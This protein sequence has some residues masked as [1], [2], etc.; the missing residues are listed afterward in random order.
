MSNR[1]GAA[2]A[3]G[4]ETGERRGS[5]AQRVHFEALVA[6][7][8]SNGGS[9]FEAESMDVSPEGMRLRTAYL[10][11]IGER[12]VC[13]FE[14]SGSEMVV[15]GEVIWRNEAAR[16]GEFGLRFT[17]LDR[18][19]AE[20]LRSL[21]AVTS[22]PSGAPG[23]GS[24]SSGQARGTRVRLHIDGLGS[25]MKARVR[26]SVT[27]EILVGS[28]LEFLRVGRS[29]ELEDVDHGVRREAHIDNVKV[30]IDPATS[31]PQL[32]VA[33]R[34][35][36]VDKKAGASASAA[37]GTAASA[38][39][40]KPAS[41][42]KART[43]A[44]PSAPSQGGGSE[45]QEA[46]TAPRAGEGR[47]EGR[48]SHRKIAS[49]EGGAE[50]G[51]EVREA[52]H[53]G[54]AEDVDG[55]DS[56]SD[57][58]GADDGDHAEAGGRAEKLKMLGDKA[59]SAGKAVANKVGPSLAAV[60]AKTKSAM[61]GLIAALQ[62]KR[63]E[64]AEANAEAEKDAAPRRVTALPP[65][66]AL[67]SEGRRLIRDENEMGEDELT[68]EPPK[69]NKRAAVIGSAVGL[70]A[71]LAVFGIT[72]FLGLHRSPE[73]ATAGAQDTAAALALPSAAPPTAPAAPASG[74]IMADVPLFG[75]T[76]LSTTEPVPAM[77]PTD[78]SAL[79]AAG[80]PG[81]APGGDPNAAAGDPE[82]DSSDGASAGGD[83][84]SGGGPAKK[85]WGQGSVRNPIVLRLKMDGPIEKLNGAAGAMGFTVS[86]PD[87]RSVSS[88]SELA[89]KDKRIA[90]L[91]V[92]NNAHGAEV[93]VQFKDGVPPY[94][95]KAKGDRLEISLGTEGRK[96]VAAKS[97]G[98][99]KK[100]S[101]ADAKKKGAAK[102]SDKKKKKKKS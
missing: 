3:P 74:T 4:A 85:E 77:A 8:E 70:L 62:K 19:T 27:G 56:D 53:A 41:G 98:S 16:G 59:A 102:S 11:Q 34:Y 46:T 24:G 63:A 88:A 28:N 5:A 65:T 61:A 36:D 29:L 30:E 13:R 1:E 7:A 18:D 94:V 72:R 33:L 45:D 66:G 96:K 9:G 31:I 84:D 93:T 58:D 44:A 92:V 76:P 97:G 17:D 80:V 82:G 47:A 67:R 75:A 23:G 21:C 69:T 68:P 2:G 32:V 37:A 51:G 71:V 73:S 20:T 78:P 64:R 99:K 25:P 48:I 86:L 54:G 52:S 81:A 14:S 55:S 100:A 6:M 40:S 83:D 10:P 91:Q 38:A 12:L 49:A 15:D 79:T 60:S 43:S 89:R 26:E 22:G 57:S 95:A 90:S 39:R 87:R 42:S 101:A 50:G 35:D